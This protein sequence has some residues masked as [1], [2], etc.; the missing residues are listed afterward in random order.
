MQLDRAKLIHDVSRAVS[1]QSASFERPP[2]PPEARHRLTSLLQKLRRSPPSVN[3]SLQFELV[4]L[5]PL[6]S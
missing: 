1:E 3:N 4:E 2:P 5:L 6:A